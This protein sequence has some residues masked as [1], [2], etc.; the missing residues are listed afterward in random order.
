MQ[1]HITFKEEFFNSVLLV[2]V[3]WS[4]IFLVVFL[5][6]CVLLFYSTRI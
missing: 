4:F 1:Y 6:S 3:V 2:L 5:F